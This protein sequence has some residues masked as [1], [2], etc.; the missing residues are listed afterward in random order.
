MRGGRLL[1]P[2]IGCAACALGCGDAAVDARFLGETL[3][4]FDFEVAGVGRPDSPEAEVEL[5]A[6]L[7]A[8]IFWHV[9]GLDGD[10]ERLIEQT[11]T[12]RAITDR[13]NTVSVRERPPGE[14]IVGGIYAIGRLMAYVDADGDGRLT[15][16]AGEAIV[17]ELE[18]AVLVLALRDIAPHEGPFARPL[19]AGL[20]RQRLPILCD[21]PPPTGA[22]C[23]PPLG[24]ACEPGAD[25][26]GAAQCLY[27]LPRSQPQA[28]PWCVVEYGDAACTPSNGRFVPAWDGDPAVV[29]GFYG[30]AC[31]ARSHCEALA[32]PDC[33]V[34]HGACVGSTPPR[35][36]LPGRG[37]RAPLCD[38]D[39]GSDVMGGGRRPGGMPPPR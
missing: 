13:V 28:R 6:G 39:D 15:V 33:D 37:V 11:S 27:S 30:P 8:A 29:S 5:P 26:C 31:D 7:R 34:M 17:S 32:G 14:A 35:I 3:A 24:E 23:T 10:P 4:T 21:G 1:A 38:R 9:D 16:E 12:G 18:G 25:A 2:L 20:Y 22:P 36:P 19:A